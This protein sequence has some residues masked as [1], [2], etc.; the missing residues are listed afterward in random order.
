MDGLGRHTTRCES[1]WAGFQ[2]GAAGGTRRQR[3]G[4]FGSAPHALMDV[5]LA[6]NISIAVI[7]LLTTIF[8]RTPLEFSI[9]PTL[10]LGPTLADWSSISPPRG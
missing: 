8:V 6:T 9:F 3:A 1:P 10:S 5:L 4:H 2:S 7:V